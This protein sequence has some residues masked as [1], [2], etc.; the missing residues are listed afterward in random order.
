M[1]IKLP[2]FPAS[3]NPL[4]QTPLQ[5]RLT[6]KQA[7]I[8]HLVHRAKSIFFK[9]NW[10]TNRTK[11]HRAKRHTERQG[12]HLNSR[13]LKLSFKSQLQRGAPRVTKHFAA[14][15]CG[16]LLC[17]SETRAVN[18]RCCGRGQALGQ[19]GNRANR[20]TSFCST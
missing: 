3:T 11:R 15:S 17:H 20:H 16:T 5:A 14:L 8:R 13:E 9:K 12:S 19:F 10:Q 6:S 7:L 4:T 2:V 1:T 18:E